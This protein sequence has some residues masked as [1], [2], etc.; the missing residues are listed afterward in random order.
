MRVGDDLAN[1][2]TQAGVELTGEGLKLSKETTIEILKVLLELLKEKENLKPGKNNLGKLLNSG[3]E[4]KMT[5]MK[6][7]DVKLFTSRAKKYGVSYAVIKE[8]RE[9]SVVYGI[10]DVELVK[11][12]FEK[13]KE[14]RMKIGIMERIKN[15]FKEMQI[16]ALKLLSSNL[17]KKLESLQY[18]KDFRETDLANDSV[19]PTEHD[20]K[21]ND[22][23]KDILTKQSDER[24]EEKKDDL[25]KDK[26]DLKQNRS[27]N[28]RTTKTNGDRESVLDKFDKIDIEKINKANKEVVKTVTK[29]K[30]F[31]RE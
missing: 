8:G 29:A 28:T 19:T 24:H 14:D 12:L 21:N 2:V 7:S 9:H 6:K 22:N 18:E 5:K 10:R 23:K 27:K 11:S 15:K 16:K 20:D 1:I 31:I 3:Q 25:V 30:D 4:L 17:D 26:K 13:V